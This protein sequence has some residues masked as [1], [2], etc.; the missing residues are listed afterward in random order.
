M[1][2][3]G[4]LGSNNSFN[5]NFDSKTQFGFK[6]GVEAVLFPLKRIS[7]FTRFNFTYFTRKNVFNVA[8]T[9]MNQLSGSVEVPFESVKATGNY[10][11]AAGIRF[12]LMCDK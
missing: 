7:V 11:W 3:D 4:D 10:G 9:S 2:V 6:S 8:E 12:N 1:I 5:G